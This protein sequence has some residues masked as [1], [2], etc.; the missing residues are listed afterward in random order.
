MRTRTQREQLP[1]VGF[2]CFM[3]QTC[4]WT[5]ER[6]LGAACAYGVGTPISE[7]LVPARSIGNG[8]NVAGHVVWAAM[9]AS[10]SSLEIGRLRRAPFAASRSAA[11]LAENGTP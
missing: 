4:F 11:S 9:M 8:L 5:G 6:I 3:K 2:G 1:P 10:R 7:T